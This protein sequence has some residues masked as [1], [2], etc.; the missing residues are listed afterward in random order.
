MIEFS[1][2]TKFSVEHGHKR[3]VLKRASFIVP[4][5]ARMAILSRDKSDGLAILK[6]LTRLSPPDSGSIKTDSRLSW[7]VGNPVGMV[8]SISAR[9]N[10]QIICALNALGTRRAN[11]IADMIADFTGLGAHID[12]PIST[13]KKGM[14]A[15]VSFALSLALK[16]DYFLIHRSL[17]A[18]AGKFRRKSRTAF[19][20]VVS[21]SG[22][23]LGSSN[24]KLAQQLCDC[25]LVIKAGEAEFFDDIEK[26]IEFFKSI[27][28]KPKQRK[29]PARPA[30]RA[31]KGTPMKPSRTKRK[32]RKS[33]HAKREAS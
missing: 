6:M 3:Y 18:G 9:R 19:L 11:R 27:T 4:D 14:M 7:I 26:G 25:C 8:K 23:V 16:F 21:R 22:L 30:K 1:N 2:V 33:R 29:K 13:Y 24:L 31:A 5:N 15:R 17:S 20:E 10:I 12:D 28:T 32:E